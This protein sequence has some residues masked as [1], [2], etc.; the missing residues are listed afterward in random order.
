MQDVCLLLIHTY[1]ILRFILNMAQ[2][3]VG[4]IDAQC[5][6]IHKPRMT[7]EIS[8]NSTA[9]DIVHHA[10]SKFIDFNC[11]FE[12]G[13][14]SLHYPDGETVIMLRK[15]KDVPFTLAAYQKELLTDYSKISLFLRL[16]ETDIG[17]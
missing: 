4:V 13:E 14:Y 9:D 8:N 11:N 2:I 1:S 10:V 16:I 15:K 17:S 7:I 12:H 3:K 5:R 6:E